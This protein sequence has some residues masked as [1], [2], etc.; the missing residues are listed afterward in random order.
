MAG[1]WEARIVIPTGG[2][3]AS[4]TDAGGTDATAISL[5]AGATYYHSSAGS[6]ANDLAA[7]IQS[8]LNASV[9]LSGTYTVTVS[10]GEGGTGKYTIASTGNFSVAWTSTGLRDCLGFSTAPG[11]AASSYT[12]EGQAE[13]LWLPDCPAETP[14]GLASSGKPRSAALVTLS[15]DGTYFATHGDV[16]R[17]NSY[18]YRAVSRARTIAASETVA[19]E[20]YEQFWLDAIRGEAAWANAGRKLRWYA[21]ADTDATYKTY[22]ATDV[23]EPM[24]ER[25]SPDYDGLWSVRLEVAE[26]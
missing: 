9:T 16:V 17:F 21:D 7:E 18:A 24:V 23:V 25:H 4:V 2:W 12:S 19:N 10:A 14:Y 3:V 22:N 6:G 13:G 11:G 26:D 15:E 5:A 1:K 20:S 8:D